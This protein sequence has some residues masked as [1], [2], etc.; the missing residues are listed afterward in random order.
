MARSRWW[1]LIAACVIISFGIQTAHSFI[2]REYTLQEVLDA[3]TNVA[4]GKVES[5]DRAKQRV[6]VKLEE[7]LK[8]K[9]ELSHIRINVAVG[10]KKKETS[11][12]MLLEKF[13]E[14]L[15]VIIFYQV[16]GS[17]LNGLG[18][19]SGTWFQI[20]GA[21]NPDKNRVWWNF[22]HIEIYMHR[23]F[24]GSTEE[25]QKVVRAA[26]SG[27]KWAS[28]GRN[29]VKVLVLA[30]NGALP[31]QGDDAASAKS[32]AEFLALKKCKKVDKWNVVY[33]QTND[34]NLSELHD[35]HILWIGVDELGKDGYHLNKKAEQRI[36]SFVRRGG[37]VIVTSQDSDA[38]KLCGIGWTPE[39]MTGVEEDA[40]RDFKPTKYA[41]D[42][43]KS[44][45]QI[46]SGTIQMDDTWTGWSGKYKVLATTNSGKSMALATLEYG[47]GMYVVTALNSET[48]NL[49]KDNAPLMENIMHFSVKWLKARS[50]SGRDVS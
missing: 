26:L 36:K 4:F 46:K 9:S 42:I 6:I 10:Q 15:P 18:Y 30:G 23:T 32:T 13:K 47:K 12:K 11:P 48:E 25:F 7:N 14:G 1:L 50:R 37:V 5:V 31:V 35:A 21:D 24:S 27:K 49:A 3:C 8:G 16:V 20:F 43:F 19:V 45:N 28:A 33:E 40:R 22:T 29:D 44:P 38:G 2:S 34:R 41:G 17:N 39:P